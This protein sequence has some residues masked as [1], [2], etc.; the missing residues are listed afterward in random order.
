[1]GDDMVALT[2]GLS[3]SAATAF[4]RRKGIEVS[5]DAEL[6]SALEPVL[7]FVLKYARV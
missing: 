7:D 3:R 2:M 5:T 4:L 6:A 1:M